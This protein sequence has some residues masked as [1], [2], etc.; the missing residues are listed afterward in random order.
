MN[1]FR[2]KLLTLQISP[3]VKAPERR[4][5]YFN[6]E[7]VKNLFGE[8]A[9]EIMM[10][11]TEGRGPAWRDGKGG[12]VDAEGKPADPAWYTEGPEYDG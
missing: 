5:K 11:D 8:D 12:F 10:D 6:Q 9:E 2:E 7:S 4:V 1:A 3:Q